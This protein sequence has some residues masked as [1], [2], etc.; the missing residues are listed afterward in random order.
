MKAVATCKQFLNT[1]EVARMLATTET[2]VRLLVFRRR[3][4]HFKVQGRL[5]F[6]QQEI[7]R[8]LELHRRTSLNE[9]GSA[10][11]VEA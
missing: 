3:I 6:D 9:V 8:W 5:L 11:E 7:L 2:A 4:P 10:H 1:V